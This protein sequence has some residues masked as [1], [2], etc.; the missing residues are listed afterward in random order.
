[1]RLTPVWDT[2]A[3]SS[4]N[5]VLRA[6][7]LIPNKP[8]RCRESIRRGVWKTLHSKNSAPKNTSV[9]LR[10]TAIAIPK[11]AEEP[12][13]NFRCISEATCDPRSSHLILSAREIALTFNA[14]L[15]LM[16]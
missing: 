14:S 3:R 7:L 10:S 11:E 12:W 15:S 13:L 16:R 4:T 1:V 9:C 8:A 2:A 6:A 5:V